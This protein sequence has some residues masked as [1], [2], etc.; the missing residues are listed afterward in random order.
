MSVNYNRLAVRHIRQHTTQHTI[1]VSFCSLIL[2]VFV[3]I[4]LSCVHQFVVPTISVL[5]TPLIPPQALS[6]MFFLITTILY[7]RYICYPVILE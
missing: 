6:S 5:Y 7:V 2:R 1:F 4:S 3:Q